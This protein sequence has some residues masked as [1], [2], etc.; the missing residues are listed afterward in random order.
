MWFRGERALCPRNMGVE[1]WHPSLL[2]PH[3]LEGGPSL[4]RFLWGINQA[5]PY[6]SGLPSGKARF[7]FETV[8]GNHHPV[9]GLQRAEQGGE[10]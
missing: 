2:F 9:E 3:L 10:R 5:H 6:M 8:P 1:P 4:V 7:E